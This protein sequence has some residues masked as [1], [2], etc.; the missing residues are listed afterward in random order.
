M[1]SRNKSNRPGKAVAPSPSTSDDS[2]EEQERN[3]FLR[4]LSV[5]EE[6]IADLSSQH[7]E[8]RQRGLSNLQHHLR[9]DVLLS[10]VQKNLDEIFDA[11]FSCF[12]KGNVENKISVLVSLNLVVMTLGNHACNEFFN[13]LPVLLEQ[14]KTGGSDVV[15]S[16][17]AE[18]IAIGVFASSPL[19]TEVAANMHKLARHFCQAE[20]NSAVK[21]SAL[22]GWGLLASLLP[23]NLLL[24]PKL[25]AMMQTF[26]LLLND[27]D[28]DVKIAAAE[29]IA[30]MYEARWR[31]E[32]RSKR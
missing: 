26:K 32:D 27:Q 28:L 14:L 18:T 12:H 5:L 31:Q 20:E 30:I 13:R 22:K 4:K 23:A 15:R 1:A 21:V 29:N 17:V 10:Q 3:S 7:A 2:G 19:P 9:T 6:S 8:T 24:T 11:L 16:S 25:M